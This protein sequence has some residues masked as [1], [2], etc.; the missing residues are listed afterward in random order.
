[1]SPKRSR[2]LHGAAGAP[3]AASEHVVR[4]VRRRRSPEAPWSWR[5]LCS[6][7]GPLGVGW[8]KADQEA[9]ELGFEHARYYTEPTQLELELELPN[10]RLRKRRAG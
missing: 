7:C 1:M 6:V 4:L 8:T 9:T 2:A 10:G 5:A 3:L